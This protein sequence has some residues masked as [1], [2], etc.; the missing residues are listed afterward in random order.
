MSN[1]QS[2]TGKICW[3]G[4][5]DPE[6]SAPSASASPTVTSTCSIG[7][8]VERTDED[9]LDREPRAPRRPQDPERVAARSRRVLERRGDLRRQPPRRVGAEG[10]E[11]AVREVEDAHQPVDERQ[12]GGDEEVHRAEP[13][14]R[15]REQDQRA[16]CPAPCTPR[17]CWTR[18]G[19]GEQLLG[20]AFVHDPAAVEDDDVLCHALADAEVLLHEQDRSSARP[21][22][23]AR[24]R[25][26]SRAR[27]ASPFVGSSIRSTAFPLRSAR[28]IATICCWPP[29]SV[30]ARWPPR[31]RSSGKSS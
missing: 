19:V 30:P 7:P 1:I 3:I 5:P 14:A 24:R 28:A 20:R 15:D 16:Q 26:R 18:S 8:A 25:P 9:E 27:D 4:A 22:A 12:P 13:E 29:E 10:D 2:G 11:R 6:T 23:R 17:S 21:P 31:S